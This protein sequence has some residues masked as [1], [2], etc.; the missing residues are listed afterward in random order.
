MEKNKRVL[1]F[2]PNSEGYGGIPNNIALLS[3]CLKEAGFETRCFD[4]T[5]LNSPPKSHFNRQK[6]GGAMKA[7]HKKAWGEWDPELPRKIPDLFINT[8]KEF[9]PALIAVTIAEVNYTHAVSLL[10]QIKKISNIP[11]VAGG[12][13]TTMCPELVIGNGCIDIACIGEGEDA[14]V[15]LAGR[16]ADGK[17]YGNVRNLWVKKEGEIIKNPLR[18]FREMDSLPFQDW[19]IFDERH[20]YKAYC[21]VF[22]RTGFFELARGCRYNCSFCATANLRK[23]Y[24][25]LGKYVRTR[26]I[27]K[28]FDEIVCM[29]EKYNLELIFFIDDNFLGMPAERFDYFCEQYKKRIGLPFYLQTRSETVREDYIKKLKEINV[30]TIAIG[31]EHGDEGLRKEYLNRHMNNDNL[32]RAFDIVHKYDIRTTANV[33]MGLPGEK[34]EMLKQT[35]E[36]LRKLK[37]WSVSVNYFQPF[38]G[39]LLRDKAVESG[40]IPA[41]YIICD[42]NTCL[43]MPEFKRDRIIHYYENFRK[44]LEGKLKIGDAQ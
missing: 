28:A 18:P 31:V 22:R 40:Y 37:P 3:A 9:D 6:H 4:T 5:F 10:S 33:I 42:S 11:V 23:I 32:Q 24:Q 35:L 19:S 21:S 44:Y 34:E 25:G 29:K 36:L 27:D 7:D 14:L 12:I 1:F 16:I 17:D 38:R 39:T 2:Y 15:E 43:D 20:V 13:T 26:S 30:S 41:D 8:I